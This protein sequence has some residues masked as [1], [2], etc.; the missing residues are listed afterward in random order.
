MKESENRFAF[1]KLN[2]DH[3]ASNLTSA[4]IALP[5][6]IPSKPSDTGLRKISGARGKP[7][8]LSKITYISDKSVNSPNQRATM[9][10]GSRS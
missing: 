1:R 8:P 4:D 7:I 2:P 5:F 10:V 6:S 3:P 9:Y